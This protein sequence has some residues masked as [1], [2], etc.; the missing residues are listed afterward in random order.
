MLTMM[1]TISVLTKLVVFLEN[2]P[3]T[4]VLIVASVGEVLIQFASIY[5]RIVKVT[6][7]R[8]GFIAKTSRTIKE[9]LTV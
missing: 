2:L 8:S 4:L 5:K 7:L 3:L 1:R 6:T 9:I